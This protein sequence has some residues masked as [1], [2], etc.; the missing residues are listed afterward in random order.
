MC[1][2]IAILAF[3]TLRFDAVGN[4]PEPL[5]TALSIGLTWRPVIVPIAGFGLA[6][7]GL[8]AD[9]CRPGAEGCLPKASNRFPDCPRWPCKANAEEYR[10]LFSVQRGAEKWNPYFPWSPRRQDQRRAQ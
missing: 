1:G 4:L 8:A 9:R 10:F 5:G 3:L 7:Y 6:L 2:A